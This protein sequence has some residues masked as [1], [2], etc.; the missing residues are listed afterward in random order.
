MPI[1]I[2]GPQATTTL[3]MLPDM[4]P[5]VTNGENINDVISGVNVAFIID[6]TPNPNPSIAP[7]IGPRNIAPIMTGMCIVV[8]DTGPIL[9]KPSGVNASIISIASNTPK[10]VKAL[11]FV[12]I[13]FSPST[14]TPYG[15]DAMF[16]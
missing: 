6:V 11:V 10:S 5:I 16:S 13:D 1:S 15:R 8:A 12:L 7:P 9:M 3:H 14:I 2:R 4:S